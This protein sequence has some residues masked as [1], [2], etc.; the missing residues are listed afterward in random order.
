M[1]PQYQ[2]KVMTSFLLWFDNHLLTKGEAFSNKTGTFHYFDDSRLPDSYNTFSSPYKQ[3]VNDSSI[4]GAII[5]S[6]ISG[7]DL[8]TYKVDDNDSV[9]SFFA[10]IG[11]GIIPPF[12][13]TTTEFF[14]VTGDLFSG[15]ENYKDD[16]VNFNPD[17]GIPSNGEFLRFNRYSSNKF[18]L[19]YHLAGASDQDGN[20]TNSFF[21]QSPS[22]PRE[23]FGYPWGGAYNSNVGS[24]GRIKRF[25]NPKDSDGN[26]IN[27]DLFFV[28]EA[29]VDFEN[30][31][32]ITTGSNIDYQQDSTIT[33]TFAVKDF[34]VYLT[35]E[36]EEDLIL[37]SKFV[38]NSRY[39][40][41][42]SG[43]KPYD[44]AVP[45][46]FINSETVQNIP[47]AFGGEDETRMTIKAVVLAEDTYSLEGVLSIFADARHKQIT[48]IPF[49]GHPSTEYGDLKNGSYN[50][51]GL[52]NAYKNDE[53]PMYIEDVV[54]SKLSDR[55]QK[56]SIGDLKVGF[57]DFD[58]HQHRFPRQ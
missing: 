22:H 39:G 11:T 16:W 19:Y 20:P 29:L 9:H 1:K 2:H 13:D 15:G 5:K 48:M 36:T 35:N 28:H 31:R 57:I 38:Q 43:I 37:E 56:Q 42:E 44:Q 53:F 23:I 18:Q 47:F 26:L 17:D 10:T 40:D 12:I 45:A 46:I 27:N 8:P 7:F 52:S 6:G 33:G 49:S 32:L 21:K 55:A 14:E 4:P 3:F 50:Y 24:D 34:N 58:V 30:G 25:F 41:S 51:T 54:V